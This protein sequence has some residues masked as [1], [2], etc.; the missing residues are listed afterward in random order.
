MRCTNV[1]V[2]SVQPDLGL[3]LDTYY[4]TPQLRDWYHIHFTDEKT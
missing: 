3:A 2:V 1:S 4:L